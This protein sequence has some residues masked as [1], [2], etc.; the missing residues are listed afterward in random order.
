MKRKIILSL[1]FLTVFLTLLWSCHSEDFIQPEDASQLFAKNA[2][3]AKFVS[4][5][6]W[7]EDVLYIGKVQQVF[8]KHANLERFSTNYGELN[9]DYAMSYG[10]FGE[11]Y[12]LVPITKKN[13]VVL[14]MEAVRIGSKVYF[15]EKKDENLQTFFEQVMYSNIVGFEEKINTQGSPSAKGLSYVCST[16]TIH[17]GCANGEVNCPPASNTTMVCEWVISNHPPKGLPPSGDPNFE[18]G[19]GND[20]YEYPEPPVETPCEKTKNILEKPTVQKIINDVKTQALKTL[21]DINEGELGFKEKKDGTIAP[22]DV[23]ASHKVIYNNVT[24]GYGGYH[25]HT[26][27]GTHMFSP[28]DIADTLL[29][30]A[31]AQDNVND[32]YFGMIAAEWCN[33]PPSN[34]KILHY[35]I[36]Y[37]GEANDLGTGGS[38]NFTQAQ[39]NQFISDYLS[40]IKD[41]TNKSLNGTTYIKNNAGDLN[42]KGLEKLFF[43]TLAVMGMDGKVNLQRIEPSG[44][45]F[46]VNLDSNNMPVA[47]PC[48]N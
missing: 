16:R 4:R 18:G 17:V 31:A 21:S 32:A 47:T 10:Q 14:L 8:L 26:A 19:G 23:N 40:I 30:F 24:D 5:S 29:G 9:W 39:V 45:V 20:G 11:K 42:E 7:K 35:V 3:S 13:K 6:L 48:P 36:Q 37:T 1:S 33:C 41:L 34:K 28:P 25:N 43:E 12:A 44:T 22:A 38:Y 27:N 15:Y 46:N 2:S